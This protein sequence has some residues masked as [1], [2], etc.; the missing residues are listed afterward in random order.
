MVGVLLQVMMMLA[1]IK[2]VAER[3]RDDGNQDAKKK[4]GIVNA[5]LLQ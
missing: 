3:M 1:G 2:P 4:P 5:R